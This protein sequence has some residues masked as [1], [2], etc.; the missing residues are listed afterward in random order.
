MWWGDDRFVPRDHPLSNVKPFYD[1]L[2][3]VGRQD[4]GSLGKRVGVGLP[5]LQTHPFRTAEAMAAGQGP[6][7]SAAA[8]ADELRAVAPMTADGW[9]VFDVMTLGMGEDGHILSVFP[10]SAALAATQLAIGVDAPT[11]I[12][13][14]VPRVTLNPKVL[15]VARTLLVIAT[16]EGK[17]ATLADV[18][19]PVG[20]ALRWPSQLAVARWSHLDRGRGGRRATP[21]M[22][23]G[24][25]AGVEPR[26]VA[27]P[28][29]TVIAVFPDGAGGRPLMLIHGTTA[30][31]TTFR[32]VGPRFAR[33]R[34]VHAIDRR[35]RGASGDTLPY[36]IEREFED[37]AAVAERLAAD[38]GRR[39]G[40]G[41]TFVRRPMRAR[42]GV[43][44][45]RHPS[46][47]LLRGCS[48]AAPASATTRPGSRPVWR[49]G[50]PRAI[51]MAPSRRS[52][53]RS[54]G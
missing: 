43:A 16:G 28:D 54:S 44:D 41:R 17:A 18:L 3:G 14:H 47:R 13:P 5:I 8:M 38:V 51:P 21:A 11:H 49:T 22:T 6:A 29:G 52:S 45:G 40:R 24:W 42:G 30:D 50:L 31:H 15:A 12:E 46:G 37:V 33:A 4:E 23:D 26:R 32:V 20:D 7:W 25:P 48:D 39:R 1:I 19:G 2:L 35:G 10:G 27:S 34:A 53:P 36:S 9:P